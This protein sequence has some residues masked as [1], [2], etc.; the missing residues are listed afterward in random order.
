MKNL[1]IV[2][3]FLSFL[4]LF[5]KTTSLNSDQNISTKT[6]ADIVVYAANK[7]DTK[8]LSYPGSVAVLD[9]FGLKDSNIISSLSNV[10]GFNFGSGFSS[11]AATSFSL[12]G[13]GGFGQGQNERIIIMQ[14]GI[15]RDFGL[16]NYETMSF[17][18]DMDI[19]KRVE[20]VKGASSILHGSGAIAGV[21]AMDSKDANDYLSDKDFGFMLGQRFE[22]NNM[23]STRTAFYAK[24]DKLPLDILTQLKSA[25]Y[26]DNKLANADVFANDENLKTAFVK[27]NLLPNEGHKLSFSMFNFIQN[28]KSTSAPTIIKKDSKDKLDSKFKLKEQDYVFNYNY[29]PNDLLNLSLKTYLATAANIRLNGNVYRKDKNKKY[30]S[31]LKNVSKFKT[32]DIE[33]TLVSGAE[34]ANSKSSFYNA[35]PVYKPI[36]L[37][38]MPQ[39]TQTYAFYLQDIMRYKR[40]ELTFGAR[41]DKFISNTK[42]HTK[43][44]KNSHLSPRFATAFELGSGFKLLYGYSQSFRAPSPT[45]T[46]IDGKLPNGL[47]AV[48]NL[49]L[50]PEIAKEYE[51]GFSYEM[52]NMILDD[53]LNVK[54]IYF[55]GDIENLI[56]T[57]RVPCDISANKFCATFVNIQNAKRKGFEIQSNYSLDDYELNLSYEKL[58]LYD[59][60]SGKN[61]NSFADKLGFEV[62]TSFVDN[63]NLA[64]QINHYFKPHQNPKFDKRIRFVAG[65]REF[66]D[67]YKVDRSYT[68]ANFKGSYTYAYSKKYFDKLILNFGINNLFNKKYLNANDYK[69]TEAVGIG[70][71]IYADFEIRF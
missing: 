41:F 43:E 9:S 58:R 6:L 60:L 4:N 24:F 16:Q 3:L 65:K 15:R 33:H 11:Q 56:S 25:K 34:Y 47:Y 20:V 7:T 35:D 63:L 27:L 51:L 2:L 29:N 69:D 12:R 55:N 21:V 62:Q 52:Q 46:L 18:T 70:R 22:T 71:N 68:I 44:F 30:G 45:E 31:E 57:Q 8:L 5:G 42:K 14:D 17:R 40:L 49:N 59:A 53:Y 39:K 61:I 38:I 19:L 26:K 10:S 48:S 66:Y 64:L 13:F 32:L 37:D 1:S 67:R 36:W 54:F 50:K 28:S 23:H